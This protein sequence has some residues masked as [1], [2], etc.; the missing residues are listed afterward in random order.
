MTDVELMGRV[1]SDAEVKSYTNGSQYISFRFATDVTTGKKKPDG[2]RDVTTYW[3]SV[4]AADRYVNMKQWITKGK[5]LFIRGA[6]SFNQYQNRNNGQ[7]EVGL[8]VH[9]KSIDFIPVS[10]NNNG[11]NNNSTTTTKP[12]PAPEMPKVT[13][14]PAPAATSV[15]SADVPDDDLPF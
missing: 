9:A 14:A 11:G 12:Q 2:T 6:F 4:T 1:V 15:A 7:M 10:N 8:N 3:W 13:S 5:P